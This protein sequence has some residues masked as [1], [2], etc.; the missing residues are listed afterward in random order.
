MHHIL[1]VNDKI[2]IVK[3]MLD[4][5]HSVAQYSLG[6]YGFPWAIKEVEQYRT[7]FWL[8]TCEYFVFSLWGRSL[9]FRQNKE[10]N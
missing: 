3:P 1:Y 10:V 4:N 7:S 9:Y 8:E 2:R 5:V 6:M